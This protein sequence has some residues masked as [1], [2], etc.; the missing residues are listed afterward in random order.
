MSERIE[1][2]PGV[3]SVTFSRHP[4]LAGSH[5]IREFYLPGQSADRNNAP[6]ANIHI[7]RAN[8]FDSM[9]LPIQL[10]RGLSPQDDATAPRAAVI[11]QTLA[12]RYFPDDTARRDRDCWRG[13]G[14]KVH[15]SASRGSADDLRALVTGTQGTRPDE[16]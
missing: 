6:G 1:A 9:E 14:R 13:A 3:R 2:V 15:Q 7:V 8:F 10:G 4:L 12:R 11:N 16:F 5:A